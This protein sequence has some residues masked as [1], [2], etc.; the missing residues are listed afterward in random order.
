MCVKF[1]IRL[2]L[3]ELTP[4]Y[5]YIYVLHLNLDKVK[6]QRSP[7]DVSDTALDLGVG[8]LPP[9]FVNKLTGK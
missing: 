7:H 8:E 9:I 1:I 5:Y 6:M 3:N 2:F 4:R